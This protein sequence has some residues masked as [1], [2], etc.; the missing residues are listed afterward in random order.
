MEL[1][2][3]SLALLE[4]TNPGAFTISRVTPD[5]IEMLY[6]SPDAAKVV[7]MEQGE[8]LSSSVADTLSAVL[9]EDRAA[10]AA[11][12]AESMGSGSDVDATYRV[13][14]KRTGPVWIRAK[15]RIIGTMNGTPIL[16][17]VLAGSPESELLAEK[18]SQLQQMVDNIPVATLIYKKQDGRV[19]VIYTNAYYRSLPFASET[20]LME[21]D[22]SGLLDMIHPDDRNQAKE[23]FSSLFASRKPGGIS[24]RSRAG[25]GTEYRWYHLKGNPVP[26]EDGSVLAYVVFNDITAEK[27]AELSALKSQ[28]MYRLAAEQSKQIIWEYDKANKR[29]IYQ[30]DSA[31]TRSVCEAQ[32][33]PPVIENV[34]ESLLT[35]VDEQY[36][37]TF[38]S[39]FYGVGSGKPGDPFEYSTTI[40]GQTHWWRVTSIPVLDRE[41]KELTV[42]CSG[43]DITE[44]KLE[45]QRYLDFFQSLDKAYPNNLGSFHLN[46]SKNICID[47]KSPLAFVMKQK[48]SGTVDGYFSEFSK[49]LADEET[50]SWFR[51]EFTREALIQSF[52]N[53]K[54]TVSF[55]YSIRYPDGLRWRQAILV[56]HRNPRT[57]DI[58]A[59]TYAVDIDKQKRGDMILQLMS[60][61]G[62][63]YIGFIDIASETFVM[64]SGNWSCTGLESG[65]RAPYRACL[66]RLA[67]GYCADAGSGAKLREQASPEAITAALEKG[68]KYSILYDFAESGGQPLKKQVVFQWFDEK[69]S[70]ILVIQS[71]ITG[72]WNGE[73]ERLRGLEEAAVLKDTVSNVPV[74]IMVIS[75]HGK[76]ISLIAENDRIRQLLGIGFQ[77]E[78]IFF[79]KIHPA[80]VKEVQTVLDRGYDFNLPVTVDF[81]FYPDQDTDIRWYRLM[82]KGVVREQDDRLVYCCMLDITEEKAAEEARAEAQRLEVRKYETQLN[83]MAS[84]NPSFAASYRLNITKDQ[85]TNMVVQDEAY[86]DLGKLAASGTASGLFE[87]TAK[88]IPDSAIAAQVRDIFSCDH[89]LRRFEQGESKISWSIRVIPSAAEYAGSS[90]RSIWCAIP[91]R[92]TWKASLTQ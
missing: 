87:A 61:E 16:Y 35:L 66:E 78:T 62:S 20:Q 84:S 9:D 34:P 40:Q 76:K 88:T 75:M 3:S 32:G 59:V 41:G 18:N 22:A 85:C 25:K 8:Y 31:Y 55:P 47:G 13:V 67:D 54:T 46:L 17:A 72:V 86:S 91:N 26:Q 69:K 89:M 50:L 65:Q 6:A 48:E 43:Q 24:Y 28:K 92:E 10:L 29:I 27:E 57:E 15:G 2:E 53:G 56:M 37:E 33:M 36:R 79:K 14:N 58:E 81:R 83:M 90:V 38:L 30:M 68:K 71:D 80:D 70:E 49:L 52:H 21:L 1:N 23:F 19:S 5:G 63:D 45:Q 51:R 74:G 60:G 64:H 42:Y 39:A 12:I 73:Q 4:Q 77:D 44:M 82:A 7:G 11:A